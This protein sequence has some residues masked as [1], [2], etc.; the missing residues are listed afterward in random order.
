M[1]RVEQVVRTALQ[2]LVQGLDRRVARVVDHVV[3]GLDH[4]VGHVLFVGERLLILPYGLLLDRVQGS[5]HVCALR[6]LC[7]IF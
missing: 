4:R 3:Q 6:R 5:V 7:L 1:H 2:L